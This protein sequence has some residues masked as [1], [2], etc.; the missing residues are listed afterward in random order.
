MNDHNQN[1]IYQAI[2]EFVVSFQWIENKIREIGW[3]ILDP[4]R[5]NWPP[6]ELRKLTNEN[7]IN[8]VYRLFIYAL[9][10][11]QLDRDLEI[12]LRK[13]FTSTVDALHQLRRDRNRILHSAYIE[14]K[15]G[16]DV[17]N[18][19]RSNPKLAINE[20]DGEY[21]YDQEILQPN[22]FQEEVLA[23]YEIQSVLNR[24]YLQLIH[25]YPIS[26]S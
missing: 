16:N 24:I 11:C 13:S 9:P 3:F 5:S 23:M 14:L 8:E 19:I 22:S 21:L 4:N 2:G 1:L 15:A 12:E 6:S 20:E 7:L 18:L 26:G 25:R 17:I 10:K